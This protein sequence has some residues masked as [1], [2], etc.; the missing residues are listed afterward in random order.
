MPEDVRIWRVGGGDVLEEIPRERLDLEKRLE[1][2]LKGDIAVLDPALLVIGRQV[3]TDFGGVID[4]LCVDRVGDVVVVELKRDKTP[5]EITAQVLDYGSW[6]RDLS[7]DRLT[8]IAEAHLGQ[9]GLE[10]AFVGKFG[11]SLPETLNEDHR[12]VI[13]ASEIDPSSERIIRYLSE[14]HGVSIN[15]ARFQ[16]FKDQQGSELISR[17]FLVEPEQLEQQ[18]RSKGTSKRRPNLTYQELEAQAAENGVWELYQRA[19]AGLERHLQ[20]FTNRSSL[21]L[22]ATMEGGRKTVVSLIPRESSAAEGLRFQVYSLRLQRLRG[23]S[24]TEVL[25]LLPSR[26]ESWKYYAAAGP[27]LQGFRGFFTTGD[28]ID[29]FLGGFA[30]QARGEGN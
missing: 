29:K 10:A 4:L 6:V 5:R 17:V 25:E 2:W 22:S 19:V 15:A 21:V 14:T 9:G 26:R 23:L 13:V 24:E 12:L 11:I 8:A 28:E 30:D 27:D 3:Q 1:T 7:N 20:K 18:S 16:H